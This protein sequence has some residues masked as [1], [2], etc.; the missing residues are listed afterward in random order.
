MTVALPRERDGDL[1]HGL[2]G[3]VGD[4][5]VPSGY[6]GR[7]ISIAVLDDTSAN[8]QRSF[9]LTLSKPANAAVGEPSARGTILSDG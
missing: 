3:K 5:H 7:V 4:G 8:G 6:D 9:T 1:G 2:H